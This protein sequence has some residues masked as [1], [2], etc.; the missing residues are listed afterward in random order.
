MIEHRRSCIPDL[1]TL[2]RPPLTLLFVGL[3]RREAWSIALPVFLCICLTDLL[4]GAA[5]RALQSSTRLGACM[6]VAFD[7]YYVTVS[8]AVL[9][10]RGL[11]PVWFSGITALKF[12]EFAATSAW[13]QGRR[14]E[15]SIWVF[16]PPGRCYGVCVF[17][18]PGAFCAAAVWP[19]AAPA[20]LILSVLTCAVGAVSS[21]NRIKQCIRFRGRNNT[22]YPAKA[23]LIAS[24]Y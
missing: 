11:A 22:V 9:N 7:L 15:K 10:A 24:R 21:A 16:D 19:A 17:L 6:D 18:A 2:A 1:I 23:R 8:L 12:A 3:I 13:L 5:A 20:C 14:N 4:D